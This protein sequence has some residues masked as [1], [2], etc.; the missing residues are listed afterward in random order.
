MRKLWLAFAAL[1][2][3]AFSARAEEGGYGHL[4]F[5]RLD[6]T[7][8]EFFWRRLKSL[9]IEEAVLTYCGEPDDFAARAKQGIRA[10]VTEAALAKAETFF[11]AEMK[12]ATAALRMRKAACHGKPAPSRG[13]LGVQIAQAPQ[14]AVVK[15]AVADSPA[16]AADLRA[17]DVIVNINGEAV[18]GPQDLS[19]RVRALAPGATVALKLLRDGA[20]RTASVKLGAMAFDAS[21]AVA[22]DMPALIS[23]SRQDLKAIAGAV[24]DM[25]AKCKS[26]IWAM[27]C[28]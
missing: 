5:S 1:L 10:C 3:L 17:G 18:A 11:N 26:S 9:A 2:A 15:E 14:G 19:A 7:Q 12:T 13:W 4:D 24:T 8:E 21:G 16:A 25:C 28:R 6:K 20:E 22:L 23:S 27:F